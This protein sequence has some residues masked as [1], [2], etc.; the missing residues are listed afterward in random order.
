[1]KSKL[2]RLRYLDVA[3]NKNLQLPKTFAKL[4]NLETISTQGTKIEESFSMTWED[5]TLAMFHSHNL[6]IKDFNH[7]Y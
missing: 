4:I 1:M 6:S 2:L 5:Q 7:R 3:Q